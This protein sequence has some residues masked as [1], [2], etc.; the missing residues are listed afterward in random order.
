MCGSANGG[1][2]K[3][4]RSAMAMLVAACRV[5]RVPSERSSTTQDGAEVEIRSSRIKHSTGCKVDLRREDH[6][7]GAPRWQPVNV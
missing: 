2:G 5:L 7:R 6:N 3:G 1:L 4:A